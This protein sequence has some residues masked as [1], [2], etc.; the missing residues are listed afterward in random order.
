MLGRWA[1]AAMLLK[2]LE[3]EMLE[4]SFIIVWTTDLLQQK[5]VNIVN[6]CLEEKV[7]PS[8]SSSDSS[9]RGC[10]LSRLGN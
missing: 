5:D 3:M 9:R 4:N 8:P 6:R 2:S 10:L 1:A 7:D